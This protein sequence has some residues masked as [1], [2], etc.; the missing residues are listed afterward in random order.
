MGL[1]AINGYDAQL[2][3]SQNVV[4]SSYFEGR[5]AF[6]DEDCKQLT[7][8]TMIAGGNFVSENLAGKWLWADNTLQLSLEDLAIDDETGEAGG[9]FRMEGPITIIGPDHFQMI[10]VPETYDMQRCK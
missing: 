8:W 6:H 3:E 1:T 2:S 5:W 9:K 7:N 10:V 4:E